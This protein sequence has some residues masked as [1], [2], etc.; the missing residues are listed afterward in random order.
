[1]R[2]IDHHIVG[3]SGGAGGRTGDVFDPNT[4]KVQASVTLGT[5]SESRGTPG[6]GRT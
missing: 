1:M 5:H 3:H 6:S 4:G 2:I